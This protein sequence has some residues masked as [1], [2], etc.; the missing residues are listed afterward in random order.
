MP[1]LYDEIFEDS[2]EKK[3]SPEN[4]FTPQEFDD[5][6]FEMDGKESL[7]EILESIKVFK[8]KAESFSKL[9]S[10]TRAI[11]HKIE[12]NILSYFI[13]TNDRFDQHNLI[14]ERKYHA[15]LTSKFERIIAPM[16][17]L[18][19]LH[20]DTIQQ[21]NRDIDK[22]YFSIDKTDHAIK[23][24]KSMAIDGINLQRR[25]LADAS[26]DLEILKDALEDTE[27]R[28]KKY[29]NAGGSNNISEAES[30]MID[31]KRITLT[32]GKIQQFD[33]PFFGLNFLDKTVISFG[34]HMKETSSQY[35]GKLLTAFEI[36]K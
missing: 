15:I 22:N 36:R 3:K 34:V 8:G 20:V 27:Q 17:E 19:K 25:I 31:Q 32:E 9:L 5:A 6:H 10:Q 12:K 28:I 35:L 4:E 26:S 7:D 21:F 30:V 14:G 1:N 2:G 23:S 16:R 33:Y 24:D 29:I 13:V 11:D 18:A